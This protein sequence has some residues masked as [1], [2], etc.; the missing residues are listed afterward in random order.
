[1]QPQINQNK[2]KL[3]VN[4]YIINKIIFI[5]LKGS[6]NPRYK[7]TLCKKFSTPQ[8]CPYGDKCQFAH[9]EQ[10]L[11]SYGQQNMMNMYNH[12]F[13]NKSQNSLLNY[14]IVKCKNWEKDKTCKYGALC[15]FA[16]GDNEMRN[17]ADNL[18]QFSSSFPLMM[19]MV[20]PA[21]GMDMAQMQQ[22]MANNQFM[23]GVPMNI[24]PNV[25]QGQINNE[26]NIQKK[27]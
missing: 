8:G 6:S 9:G 26:T 7:T 12:N 2:N 20:M 19:P 17:K 3:K 24:N 25:E 16:H 22:L 21:Q 13:N 18:Y 11:H 15:T 5:W 27:E 10:D 23:M 4:I 1:M 14:K